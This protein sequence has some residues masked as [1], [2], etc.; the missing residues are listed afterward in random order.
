MSAHPSPKLPSY[1]REALRG[2]K[3]AVA[4]CTAEGEPLKWWIGSGWSK[5]FRA[6]LREAQS[7]SYAA[8][9][10]LERTRLRL[11]CEWIAG[12]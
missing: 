4:L 2:G 3:V 8:V 10:R 12:Q 7:F 11:A 6:A 5:N 9:W 1:N